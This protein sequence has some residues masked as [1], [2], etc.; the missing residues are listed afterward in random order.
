[1]SATLK[2]PPNVLLGMPN[3]LFIDLSTHAVVAQQDTSHRMRLFPARRRR[4]H[5]MPNFD[6]IELKMNAMVA[7]TSRAA[8]LN[9]LKQ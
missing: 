5:C 1:M 4:T 7:N 6:W 9:E 8:T 3:Y 2:K